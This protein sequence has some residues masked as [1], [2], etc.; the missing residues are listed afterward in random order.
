M[1][2]HTLGPWHAARKSEKS[3]NVGVY[4]AQGKEVAHIGVKSVFTGFRRDSDARLIAAAPELLE[5]LT[6]GAQINTPDFLDWIADRLVHVYGESPHI[7]FVI[8]LRE[9]AK[10]ARAA[11]AK[12][13]GTNNER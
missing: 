6:M 10:A 9:R 3:W 7:D 8:S 1:T 12:A 11:I 2:G 5:A 13:T 4:D